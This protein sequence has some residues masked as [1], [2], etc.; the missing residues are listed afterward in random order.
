MN[1]KEFAANIS[2]LNINDCSI[3]H[4]NFYS[5]SA[6]RGSSP[7]WTT[8]EKAYIL[9]LFLFVLTVCIIYVLAVIT[10]FYE[11][12]AANFSCTIKKCVYFCTRFAKV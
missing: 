5:G 11:H 6:S 8:R 2:S 3:N 1:V 4:N 10:L 12:S 7:R 9:C